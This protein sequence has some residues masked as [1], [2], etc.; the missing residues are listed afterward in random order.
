MNKQGIKRICIGRVTSVHGIRGG[1]CV[2]TFTEDPQ[3]IVNYDVVYDGD[4]K[5]FAIL[6]GHPKKP[7]VMVVYLEGVE[8]RSAAEVLKGTELFADS[9]HQEVLAEDEFY[10]S[11][12]VGLSARTPDGVELGTVSAV[13]NF[14]AGDLLDIQPKGNCKSVIL[15]FNREMVPEIKLADKYVI[16]NEDAFRQMQAN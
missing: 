13:Y 4:G 10:C 16:V 12:L 1:V 5:Q 6:R 8:D 3:A 14:G 11:D 15:A 2:K 9:D 7:G